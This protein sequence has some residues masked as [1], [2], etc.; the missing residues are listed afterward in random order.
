MTTKP[1]KTTRR[2]FIMGCSAAVAAMS[3]SRFGHVAFGQAGAG[4]EVLVVVFLRGGIDALNLVM[5][6]DGADRGF[7]ETARPDIAVPTTGANAALSLNAQFG[8]HPAAAPIY[9]LYQ[10]GKLSV[11]LASGLGE[12]NRSHFDSMRFMEQGVVGSTPISSGWLT[13]HLQTSS[14]MPGDIVIPSMALGNLQQQSLLGSNETINLASAGSFALNTG[15][16]QWRA[17]QRLAL[18]RLLQNDS[19]WMHTTSEQALDALDVIELNVDDD[20]MPANGAAYP[21]TT[22]G[23][24]LETIAQVVKLDLGLR[25]VT[26]DLGGWD[27]HNGQG[28][29]GGG[30][31]AGQVQQL[32]EGLKAL[33]V[34]LDGAGAANHTQRLNVAVMSEFGRRLRQNADR[35]SDHGHGGHMLVLSGNALGGIHGTWPGLANAQLFDGADLAVTTDYRRVLTE[36]L[37]R[38]MGNPFVGEI[39]PGYMNYKPLGIVQGVDLPPVYGEAL[40]RDGFEDGDTSAWDTTVG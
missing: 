24:Q 37:I 31:F 2:N 15:P 18:R 35:G 19:T 4:E 33:Y 11:V 27:T 5:P 12:A 25:V 38:R 30:Y 17:P 29:D 26:I 32:M 23:R 6:I 14:G 21:N 22:F 39:F 9:D 20:Y 16:S 36:L 10:D 40:F 28:D 7:Y 34:D 1:G 13:R 8:L 3:G